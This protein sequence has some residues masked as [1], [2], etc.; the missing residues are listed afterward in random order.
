MKKRTEGITILALLALCL[1][2]WNMLSQLYVVL[3]LPRTY[4]Y[5]ATEQSY[6]TFRALLRLFHLKINLPWLFLN[7]LYCFSAYETLK[8]KDGPRLILVIISFI[9]IF[10]TII[11]QLVSY[12]LFPTAPMTQM[13]LYGATISYELTVPFS[14]SILIYFFIVIYFT[15]PKVK[16]LFD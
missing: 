16:G 15:Q 11:S 7:I 6:T 4:S 9:L 14:P 5:W 8:L 1:G 10:V 3:W 2:L 12:Y 13:L